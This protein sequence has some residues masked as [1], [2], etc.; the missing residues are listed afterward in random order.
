MLQLYKQVM[1]IRDVPNAHLSSGDIATLV[2]FIDHP[3]GGE[4]GVVLEVFTVLGESID[5]VTVPISAIAALNADLIP[6]ARA[7]T[8]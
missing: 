3:L 6:A 2:D 8:S 4:Q 1:L 7:R 5:V